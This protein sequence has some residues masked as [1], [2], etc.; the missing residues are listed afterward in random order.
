MVRNIF[1]TVAWSLLLACA[2]RLVEGDT[3][4]RSPRWTQYENM[5]LLGK[6]VTGATLGIV[7]MGCIGAEV[8][9]R[10]AGFRMKVLYCNRTRRSPE[11]EG[12]LSAQY[13]DKAMLLAQSD[14]VVLLCPM[15]PET[16]HF[17]DATALAAMKKDA[18]LINVARGGVVDTEALLSALKDGSIGAAGLDVTE[19][20]P[21]PRDHE[22]L[23]L[24]NVILAP[25][26]GSATANVR[27]AM[28]KRT[29]ANLVAGLEG[30][31]LEALCN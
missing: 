4:A 23:S 14:F 24:S 6:D 11:D 30:R 3:L 28:A 29:A 8:A 2:R 21:L 10:A 17:I 9:R 27:L 22:L 25:H 16:R 15:S 12:E 20:E 19:P 13:V 1:V 18:V 5:V 7:G 26:R 31:Q